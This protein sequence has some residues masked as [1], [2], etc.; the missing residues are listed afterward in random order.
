MDRPGVA[1][2]QLGSDHCG[3]WF[4]SPSFPLIR[5]VF[6]VISPGKKNFLVR[7]LYAPVLPK[8]RVPDGYLTQTKSLVSS[9]AP[10]SRRKP[11]CMPTLSPLC[12]RSHP[13]SYRLL[14][15]FGILG[16]LQGSRHPNV[17]RRVKLTVSIITEQEHYR[18][19]V[20]GPPTLSTRRRV[21][22]D[23]D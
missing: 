2:A 14:R 16:L 23:A 17:S 6:L 4:F 12:L 5:G 10:R 22:D 8:K 11:N 9:I 20:K 1:V 7:L 21:S 18:G 3:D 15:L 19:S 13:Y